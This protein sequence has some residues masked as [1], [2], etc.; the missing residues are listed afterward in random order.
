MNRLVLQRIYQGDDCTLGVLHDNM[1]RR[2]CFTLEEPWK[3]NKKGI[4]CVPTGIYKCVPH[5]GTKFKDVW[6]LESVPDRSAI[7]IHQGN[8]TDDIE[9]CILVGQYWGRLKG[10][11]A[12]MDSVGALNSLKSFVGRGG[13]KILKEFELEIVNL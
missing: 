7:L 13:N 11:R 9:G 10:K 1:K 5:N 2:I 8:T 12:V 4:S 3:D 6:R